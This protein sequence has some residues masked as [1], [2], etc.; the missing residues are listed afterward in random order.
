M[1]YP[2]SGTVSLGSGITGWDNV[3]A[4]PVTV[5]TPAIWAVGNQ[6][7]TP[8]VELSELSEEERENRSAGWV[9]AMEGGVP[10]I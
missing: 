7:C 5:M 8:A 9:G 4:Q 1:V 2:E 10:G 3:G 6:L